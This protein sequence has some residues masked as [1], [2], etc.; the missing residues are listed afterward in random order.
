MQGSFTSLPNPS[1]PFQV[2][3][4]TSDYAIDVVLY[5]DGKP[6]AFENKKLDYAQCRYTVQEKKLFAIIHPLKSWR[7]YLYGNRFVVTM[8]H[9][10]LKYFCD[11]Q[12]LKGRKA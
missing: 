5:Q 4:N 12:D 3:T 6:I 1:K 2:E 9:E 7:H 11:Q 8:D 10:F